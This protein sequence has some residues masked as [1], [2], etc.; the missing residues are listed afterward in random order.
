MQTDSPA[1][2]TFVI[3]G[4]TGNLSRV[5]L[6]PALYHLEHDP[7]EKY[8]IAKNHPEVIAELTKL[9][10]DHKEAMVPGKQQLERRRSRRC[11]RL[12][13]SRSGTRR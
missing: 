8:D 1:P 4:A 10:A 11:R 12:R 2:C 7:S 13:S 5:K 9:A 3:F 6:L